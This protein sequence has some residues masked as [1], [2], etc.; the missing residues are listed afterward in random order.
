MIF[1]FP[2]SIVPVLGDISIHDLELSSVKGIVSDCLFSSVRVFSR[3]FLSKERFYGDA[4][5]RSLTNEK[6]AL[7]V[8]S[9]VTTTDLESETYPSLDTDIW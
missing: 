5:G 4:D 9:G 6:S 7:D 8:F 1:W 3:S 2:D